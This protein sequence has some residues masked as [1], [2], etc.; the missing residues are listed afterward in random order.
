MKQNIWGKR[1]VRIPAVAVLAGLVFLL[2]GCG[3]APIRQQNRVDTAM[4]TIVTQTLYVQQGREQSALK[5]EPEDRA[6]EES[7]SIMQLLADLEQQELSWRIESSEVARIN[8]QNAM[9]EEANVISVSSS[10][11]EILGRIWQVSA[12]SGGALDVT[13]GRLSRLW[14]LDELAV[15][16]GGG[17]ETLSD[18][19]E[20]PAD[21]GEPGDNDAAG[22][23]SEP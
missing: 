7:A 22:K 10:M 17:N 4:G 6:D 1:V 11:Q 3:A 16:A 20:A 23:D 13:L 9:G 18:S 12:D 5:S 8:A 21:E 14:N 2:T 15:S 19:A